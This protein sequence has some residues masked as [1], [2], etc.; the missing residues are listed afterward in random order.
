MIT[1]NGEILTRIPNPLPHVEGAVTAEDLHKV[2]N[3][4]PD[5]E[6]S[7]VLKADEI[8]VKGL[9]RS[10]GLKLQAKVSLP[11][12]NVPKPKKWRRV[13]EVLTGVMLQAA[14]VCGR[15]ETQPRTT[16]IHITEKV[17]EAC[18][19]F[20]MFRY[21][22]DTRFTKECLIPATSI[23]AIGSL[24]FTHVCQD[25]GWIHFKTTSKHVVSVCC[26]KG[27]YPNLTPLLKLNNPRKVVL[28]ANLADILSRAEVMQESSLDSRVQITIANGRLTLKAQKDAGWFKEDKRVSYKGPAL[29]FQVHPKFLMDVLEKTRSV[30]I[31]DNRMALE[32]KDVKF[33]VCLEVTDE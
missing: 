3:K 20:R 24:V 17:V 19:N 7:V 1:F 13:P 14:R 15:D 32:A 9:R 30:K 29:K 18:D 26:S 4:F 5:D 6:I 8:V 12:A 10:A 31:A 16:E 33:L 28:P 25:V 11:F 22:L 2:L 27:K 23:E 21:K